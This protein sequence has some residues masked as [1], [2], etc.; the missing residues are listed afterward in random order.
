MPIAIG[1]ALCFILSY[2]VIFRKSRKCILTVILFFRE[3]E[4]ENLFKTQNLRRY[5]LTL[6]AWPKYQL[7]KVCKFLKPTSVSIFVG[8]L[9]TIYVV[10]SFVIQK[11][12]CGAQHT[13]QAW[14][15]NVSHLIAAVV[16]CSW[17]SGHT[18]V[19]FRTLL[20]LK[21]K[22]WQMRSVCFFVLLNQSTITAA[23]KFRHCQYL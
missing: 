5:A 13:W 20:N 7:H 18:R 22:E 2:V 11:F 3:N 17:S 19:S 16:P 15:T 12:S 4:H 21:K 23:P 1:L 10:N 14:F 9:N 8:I 6:S